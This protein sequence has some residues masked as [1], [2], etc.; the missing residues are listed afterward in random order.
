L[1]IGMFRAGGSGAI[2]ATSIRTI[3]KNLIYQ[4]AEI[5]INNFFILTS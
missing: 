5:S 3:S 4:L 2:S 1:T